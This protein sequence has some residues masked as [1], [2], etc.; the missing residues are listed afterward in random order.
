VVATGNPGTRGPGGKPIRNP[1]EEFVRFF[2]GDGE[3]EPT[4]YQR[5]IP[6]ALRMMNSGQFLNPRSEAFV[7]KQI[8]EPGMTPARAV[9][10]LYLRVLSRL[11][12][13]AESKLML[14]YLEQPGAER[15][16]L[17]AEIFWALLNSSEFSLNH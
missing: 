17:Y 2:R 9:E 8:V 12:S 6:E 14:K 13:A 5:G 1:R 7:I 4:D 11:P 10:R 3:A 16:Q 15:H